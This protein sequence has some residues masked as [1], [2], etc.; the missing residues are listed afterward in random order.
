MI[1]KLFGPSIYYASDKN[2][3]EALTQ[4]KVDSKTIYN[5][6]ESRNIIVSKNSDRDEL[7]AY[8]AR[9]NHDYFDHRDISEKLGVVPRRE[10]VTSM[11]IVGEIPF[12]AVQQAIESLKSDMREVGDIVQISRNDDNIKVNIQYSHINY[13]LSEFSQV[14]VR[15]GEIEFVKTENGYLIRNTQNEFINNARDTIIS[16]IEKSQESEI[17]KETVSLFEITSHQL[18]NKFFYNL[19]TKNTGYPKVDVTDVYVYKAKP[20]DN[21]ESE[22]IEQDTSD[23]HIERV[24]LRGND[25]TRSELLN[26]LVDEDTYYIIKA[27]WHM[28]D[29]L[30]SG[31]VYAVEAV[32]SDPKECTGF[33]FLLRG[34]YPYEEGIV[35]K[36][37]RSPTSSEINKISLAIEN[38]SRELVK[39]LRDEFFK[40]QS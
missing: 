5:L 25:V 23:A 13:K 1:K 22:S 34:V 6:F 10:R 31:N 8:F 9:L 38:K 15:D 21:I 36:K 27:G 2:I 3:F 40:Q 37:R 28:R 12:E 32:F 26:E 16:N 35:S 17:E 11:D 4:H 7:A 29:S 33:S 14:K 18:R 19:I 30:S 39:E 24:L 20:E